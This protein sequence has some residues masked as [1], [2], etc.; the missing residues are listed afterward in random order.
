[1]LRQ[2]LQT[3]AVKYNLGQKRYI[4]HYIYR[5]GKNALYKSRTKTATYFYEFLP[6]KTTYANELPEETTCEKN[7]QKRPPSRGGKRRQATRGDT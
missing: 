3:G 1:M 7:C 5:A 2:V 6:K 4:M